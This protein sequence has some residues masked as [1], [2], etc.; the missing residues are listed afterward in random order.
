MPEKERNERRLAPLEESAQHERKKP[1]QKQENNDEHVGHRR[2]EI[3]ADLSFG[4]G[5]DIG[6]GI[7]FGPSFT[8]SGNVIARNTSS[9]RP[10]SVCNSS[11]RQPSRIET[12]ATLRAS[13]PFMFLRSETAPATSER[14]FNSCGV[15]FATILPRSMMMARVQAAST[16]SRICVEKMI[17]F[18]SPIRRMRL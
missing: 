4:N 14:C 17:A 3:T 18:F 15:P 13:S 11:I 10:S 9:N 7:H 1:A 16:S 5:P 2:G 8:V 6:P 12:S